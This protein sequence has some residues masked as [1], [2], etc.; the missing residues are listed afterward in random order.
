MQ[1]VRLVNLVVVA[2][3]LSFSLALA[4][5]ATDTS[6]EVNALR[7]QWADLYNE[8]DIAG[9]ADIYAEDAT[10]YTNTGEVVEGRE[11][12]QENLQG[13]YDE[14][15]TEVSIEA[16]ETEELGDMAYDLGRYTLRTADGETVV[17]GYY[18]VILRRVDGEWRI[19]RHI[20]NMIMPEMENGEG[21]Q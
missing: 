12:I 3:L 20:S 2:M 15:V 8:G 21:D 4:Q 14:G 19:H 7:Q 1:R 10:L 17:E 5:E 13:G 6:E 9:V 16:S 18:V 11:A